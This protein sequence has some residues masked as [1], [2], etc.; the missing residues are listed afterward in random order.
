MKNII[1]VGYPKSGNT[2]LRGVVADL[3]GCPTAG[4]LGNANRLLEDNPEMTEE[5][6]CFKSHLQ[7]HELKLDRANKNGE[8]HVIYAIRDPRDVAI[9]GAH[10]FQFHRLPWLQEHLNKLWQGHILYRAIY[11]MVSSEE[12]RINQMIEAVLYGSRDVHRYCCTS[13][14]LHYQPF[15][16]AGHLFVRYE[17]MLE[18]PK[19]E[20]KRIL[21]YLN[22]DRTDALIEQVI[23]QNSFARKRKAFLKKGKRWNV[24]FLRSGTQGQ[25][26]NKLSHSQK[27]RFIDLLFNDLKKLSYVTDEDSRRFNSLDRFWCLPRVHK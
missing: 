21:N 14:Q 8:N 15:M 5:F 1:V 4:F 11:P 13:W 10:Y 23:D 12:F 7:L 26:R 22:L 9:S 6:R 25:W 18:N 20:C 24:K 3:V 19:N 17:D 27:I 2:W 16:E